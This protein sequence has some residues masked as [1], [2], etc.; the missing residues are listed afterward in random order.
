MERQLEHPDF[1]F[2]I[3]W[4]ICN[5]V[6]GIYTVLSTKSGLLYNTFGDSQI[7]IGP[8]VWMETTQTPDFEED[9]ELFKTWTTKAHADGLLFR[10]GRWQVPGK[11]IVILVDFRQYFQNR[12]VIFA[13][14]WEKYKLDSLSGGWDYI[15]P[16]MFGYA[17]AK[18]IES[19]YNF[20]ISASDT[21]MAQFH[22]WMSGMGILYL[23][24]KLPQISTIFTTHATIMGRCIAGN[25]LPLY[26]DLY[27][28]NPDDLANRFNIRAKYSMEK[29][30]VTLC[31]VFTTVSELTSNECKA[32]YKRSADVILPNGFDRS[33]SP[34]I[35]YCDGLRKDAKKTIL[36]V[37]SAMCNETFS[38]DTHIILTSG[39]YEFHN[40]GIDMFI[41]VL[42]K[43]NTCDI[44]ENLIAVIAVPANSKG[45]VYELKEKL[46][47]NKDVVVS[48][49]R[50]THE[51]RHANSDAILNACDRNNLY[52]DSGSK[53]KVMFIPVYLN[54]DDGIFNMSYYKLLSGADLSVFASYYEPWGYTPLESIA[55]SVPTVTSNLSGFGKWIEGTGAA[56]EQGVCILNRNDDNYDE[57]AKNLLTYIKDFFV[58]YN[59]DEQAKIRENAFKTSDGFLWDTLLDN[60]FKAYKAALNISLGRESLYKDRVLDYET[61]VEEDLS[62]TAP[63]WR[64]V[65][66]KQALPECLKALR[67]LSMNFWWSWN[68]EAE[69][70]FRSINPER[71]EELQHNPIAIIESLSVK[72]IEE[73]ENDASFRES[74][75]N[76]FQEFCSYMEQGKKKKDPSI[77]YFSM[78]YGIHNSLKIF[79]GGLGMLAGDYLKEMSDCNVNITGIGLMY[80]YGYFKQ[81]LNPD[82][83]QVAIDTPQRFTHL[84]IIPVRDANGEWVKVKIALPARNMTAKVWRVDVGRVPLY[85]LDTDIECN[86]EADRSVTHHLYGG[87]RENRLKQE[88]LL[89]VGGIRLLRQLNLNP[90]LYHLN[91][92]HA[93]FAGL[94]RLRE[95][96]QDSHFSFGK[97]LEIVRASTLFTTHTPVPAGHDYFTEDLLRTYIPHYADRLTISWQQMINMGKMHPN[98]NEKFSMSVLAISTAEEINGVSKIHGRVTRDMFLDLYQGYYADELPIGYVTNGVHYPSWVSPKWHKLHSEI[99]GEGFITDQSNLKYWEKIYDV[100]NEVIWKTRN[101]LRAILISTLKQRLREEMTKRLES[102]K[103]IIKAVDELN[104]NK[105]T[106]GFARRFATYKRAHLLFQNLDRLNAIVNSPKCPVQFI[107]AGKAH[108]ADKAG[109]DLIK[110]I[111]EI[112]RRPEFIG[113]I[114]FVEDYDMELAKKL[115][116]GVDVWMNTPTRPLEASGTSGEKAVMN[117]VL[118]FSVLDGWWAEGYKEGA[119][120]ALKEERTYDNQEYQ[121]I[122]D[123]ETMYQLLENEIIP[124]FYNRTSQDIPEDWLKQI[125][126]TFAQIAPHFTMKRMVDDYLSNFYSKLA[127]RSQKYIDSGY[128]IPSDYSA[129]KKKV[130]RAWNNIEVKAI[131]IPDSSSKTFKVG[132]KFDI[133][134]VLKMNGLDAKDIA[135]DVIH[136]RKENDMHKPYIKCSRMTPGEKI[137]ST[138]EYHLSEVIKSPGIVDV[139]IRMRPQ[140]ED[141]PYEQDLRLVR[142]I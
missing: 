74:L 70:M 73:L 2:E 139:S 67:K 22:E 44:K 39:R 59:K 18:V 29:L 14:Y 90:Q 132:D 95:Y 140:N 56:K 121:D 116:Q 57:A 62:L 38:E 131:N 48:E 114:V 77:A 85:L 55:Y 97:S 58:A 40:K 101:E 15:E 30:S 137:G 105:L 4:E 32:F 130:I 133:S 83:S 52:N 94:E 37:A 84:P 87:D 34:D 23:K 106:F 11:P 28:V 41:D 61:A 50:M 10:I 49:K 135:L 79:S 63:V 78:E 123:S 107:F 13:E 31:D 125:K 7:Y 17:A 129:W 99:F 46:S 115:V 8:D 93:A 100:D 103:S 24:D 53:V 71:W 81:S 88:L 122:L 64:K 54:G 33:L 108:P 138:V 120:W 45:P 82:G 47:G 142:W 102:P 27:N 68:H 91:E 127:A 110:G 69:K 1:L 35:N 25:C 6:G 124:M 113:K 75:D 86:W 51:I 12:N 128:K 66:V 126:N 5:K 72:E 60:Y 89:G 76:V 20:N 112:S 96:V 19:F 42:G 119:G 65:Y 80:R 117:G 136:G 16:V 118:N 98:S 9:K 109:Q 26:K 43:L 36:N 92:G 134:I 141:M 21:I 111:I 104:A 3:S